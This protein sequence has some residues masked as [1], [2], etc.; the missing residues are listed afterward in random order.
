M[1][2]I[3]NRAGSRIVSLGKTVDGAFFAAFLM[4]LSGS[5]LY[6]FGEFYRFVVVTNAKK[7][8]K[9]STYFGRLFPMPKSGVWEFG[10]TH[11][12]LLCLIVCFLSMGESEFASAKKKKKKRKDD[13]DSD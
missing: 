2:D 12:L 10:L 13:S 1:I 5:T 7:M 11:V 8:G 9:I 4:L 3:G 6:M